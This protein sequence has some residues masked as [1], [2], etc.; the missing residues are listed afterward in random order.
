MSNRL[1]ARKEL[2]AVSPRLRPSLDL[3]FLAGV[4][5][6]QMTFTRGCPATYFDTAGTMQIAAHNLIFPSVPATGW[7]IVGPVTLGTPTAAPDNTAAS[8]FASTGT[9]TAVRQLF[10]S[11]TVVASTTYTA[12][13]YLKAGPHNAHIQIN[14]TGDTSACV[15]YFDLAGG[16]GLVGADLIA[17]FTGKSVAITSVGNGWYRCSFTFTMPA[18]KTTAKVYIGPCLTVSAVGDNRSYTGVAGQ[19][20]YVWGV[21]LEI[22]ST[23]SVYVPTVAAA[24]SAPRFDYD[25]ATLAPLGLLIEEARTNLALQSGDLSNAAWHPA[26]VTVALPVVT[27][28]QAVAP[29][30]TTTAAKIVFPAVPNA[31]NAATIY[32]S[33]AST[34]AAYSLSVWLKGNAGGEQ[35]YILTTP[36]SVTYYQQVV[37]LTTAWQRFTLVTPNLTATGWFFQIGCDR[38]SAGQSATLAQT[39]FAWGAQ[40]ELGAF[41]TSYIPTITATVQ[42][43]ADVPV[44][45]DTGWLKSGAGVAVLTATTLPGASANVSQVGDGSNANPVASLFTATPDGRYRRVRYWRNGLTAAQL[46][47]ALQ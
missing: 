17:G 6:P 34:A 14:A 5:D 8:F 42:R 41:A 25:P 47:S 45:V 27:G 15:A 26:S 16:T 7:T 18:A 35:L 38:R 9:T 22:G 46:A 21:Q 40:Q 28:A 20:V 37:T 4:L 23:P 10:V 31:G 13:A 11:G 19:G 39:I 3:N 29:D 1:G 24:T 12:S 43:A 30:G 33:V 36:D 44:S 32:Q 2:L